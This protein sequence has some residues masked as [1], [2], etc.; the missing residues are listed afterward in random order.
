MFRV[1]VSRTTSW[2]EPSWE[3]VEET[4]RTFEEGETFGEEWQAKQEPV[5][6]FDGWHNVGTFEVVEE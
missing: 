5:E 4:F 2:E 1:K 6:F 3:K